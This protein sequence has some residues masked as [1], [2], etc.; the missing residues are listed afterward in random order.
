MVQYSK[1]ERVMENRDHFKNGTSSKSLKS[2]SNHINRYFFLFIFLFYS[3]LLK[4]QFVNE[5]YDKSIVNNH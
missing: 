4:A 3:F 2:R 5:K 1:F